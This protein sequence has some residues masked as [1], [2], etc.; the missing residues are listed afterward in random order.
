MLRCSIVVVILRGWLAHRKNARDNRPRKSRGPK[1]PTLQALPQE[2][3]ATRVHACPRARP[4]PAPLG[5]RWA[6]RPE[7]PQTLLPRARS[8]NWRA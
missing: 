6:R 4:L 2:R 3:G 8:G 7:R 1:F 5:A